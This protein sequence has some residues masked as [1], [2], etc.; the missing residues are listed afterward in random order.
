MFG[1]KYS[2]REIVLVPF[3]YSDLTAIKKRPVL[4]V[5][6][7]KYNQKYEDVLVCVITSK[8]FQDNY[9]VEVNNDALEYGIL[10]E[11][12]VIK[13]AKLFSVNKNN[14]I[15]KFSILK[16]DIYKHVSDLITHLISID[17]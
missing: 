15:K 5:S 11:V 14:I 9:S 6:N 7:N 2:Q 12:S 8:Q 10:P 16:P 4:I 13:T 17:N 1:M 3:P